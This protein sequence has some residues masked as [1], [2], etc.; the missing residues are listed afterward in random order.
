M[1]TKVLLSLA[2]VCASN[3]ALAVDV[4]PT[5]NPLSEAT[6]VMDLCA[7]VAKNISSIKP[8]AGHAEARAAEQFN[9]TLIKEHEKA[10]LA[11]PAGSPAVP[12]DASQ[13]KQITPEQQAFLTNIRAQRRQ[14]Q[15]CGEVYS[16][17]NAGMQA[18]VKK[19]S[20]ALADPKKKPNEDDKKVGAAIVAYM[21]SGENL[22]A[23]IAV[24]S[25]DEVLQRYVE[26]TIRKYFL[27]QN[28]TTE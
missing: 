22:S 18:F 19:T 2:L 11:K 10:Q 13:F 3:I 20:D 28:I 1:K 14:L 15:Q 8:P 16:K 23:S 6:R 27:G 24:L 17:A 5:I 12:V 4:A 26:R 25:K 7:T 9:Q 21:Q